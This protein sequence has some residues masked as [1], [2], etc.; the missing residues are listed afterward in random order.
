MSRDLVAGRL[1]RWGDIDGPEIALWA[2]YPS[3]RLLSSRVSAFLDHLKEA[4]PSGTP[5]E[6][7]NYIES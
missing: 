4:F 2:L 6:L 5:N 1:A 3:K 7:A